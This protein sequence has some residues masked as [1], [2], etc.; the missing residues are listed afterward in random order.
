MPNNLLPCWCLIGSGAKSLVPTCNQEER[1]CCAGQHPSPSAS[2]QPRNSEASL[3][4]TF[5]CPISTAV[6]TRNSSFVMYRS[7]LTSSFIFP[8]VYTAPPPLCTQV[9]FICPAVAT[10]TS[11]EQL[12]QSRVIWSP[13]IV[14]GAC[15]FPPLSKQLNVA[16]HRFQRHFKILH[17]PEGPVTVCQ[18]FP[19]ANL[20]LGSSNWAP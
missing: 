17:P 13:R 20:K 19:C 11:R 2:G 12:K 10:A 7:T 3:P 4:L 6:R 16:S 8:C 1:K 18:P 15:C 14:H 9:R 5:F